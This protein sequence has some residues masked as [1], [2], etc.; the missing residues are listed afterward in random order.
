MKKLIVAASLFTSL[1]LTG[2][3]SSGDGQ[4][5]QENANN[6]QLQINSLNV[7]LQSVEYRLQKLEAKTNNELINSNGYCY[8]NSG[9][10]STGTKLY[11]R[12]CVLDNGAAYWK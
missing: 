5:L 9:K 10:Y 12:T 4:K 1:L 6:Q 3:V 2:C 11:G 8:L 7:R